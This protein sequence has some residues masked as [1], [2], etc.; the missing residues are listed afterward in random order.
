MTR[1]SSK[2]NSLLSQGPKDRKNSQC[3][4]KMTML[5]LPMCIL[6]VDKNLFIANFQFFKTVHSLQNLKNSHCEGVLRRQY[7]QLWVN[8]FSS[9]SS[10]ALATF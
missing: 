6:K 4:C 2:N 10:S 7:S 9:N 1:N 8:I 5:K 3:L